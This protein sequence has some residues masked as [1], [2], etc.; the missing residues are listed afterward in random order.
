MYNTI[1]PKMNIFRTIIYLLI[2]IKEYDPSP[3]NAKFPS[4]SSCYI[5]DYMSYAF[6]YN[7]LA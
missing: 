4:S 1:L 6:R 2:N 5:T 3:S 7:C